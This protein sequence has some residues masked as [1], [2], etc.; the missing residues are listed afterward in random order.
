MKKLKHYIGGKWVYGGMKVKRTSP[1][2]G[3]AAFLVPYAD[4]RTIR[5]AVSVAQQAQKEW[6]T[7]TPANRAQVL[8]KCAEWL[9]EKYGQ[10]GENTA[11]KE[12]IRSSVGKPLAE[13]DIEIIETSDFIRYFCTITAETLGEE[14]LSLDEKLWPTKASVV[15]HA[16]HGV[17]AII[18]PWNYPLEMIAWAAFPAML[19]GNAVLIKPSERSPDIGVIFGEMA[20]ETGIPNGVLNVVLGN[21]ETGRLLTRTDGVDFVSFTGSVAAG[22]EVALESAKRHKGYLL[23]MGGNDPAIVLDDADLE[24]ATNGVLWGK[25]CNAGQV[26]VG[27]KRAYV[28]R[29]VYQEF[30]DKI[31]TKVRALDI[32]RDIG[33]MIDREQVKT[34]DGF[35]RDAKKKGAVVL[36]G[37]HTTNN[38]LTYIPTVLEKVPRA[39]RLYS[40]ECFGPILPLAQFGTDEEAI[41]LA[42]EGNYGLGASIWTRNV[43]RA[44]RIADKLEA[45]MVWINDVNVA[46]PQA[47]WGGWRNSGIGYEL[48]KEA[49]RH[50]TRP[51]HIS[52]EK[53]ADKRRQWWFPY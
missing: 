50:Y 49:I 25:F 38:G 28:A 20:E 41:R 17:V 51:K 45:G 9:V 23:E 40:E 52:Y 5:S 30:R 4:A 36:H 33:P 43:E 27:V 13:A 34:V 11:I 39:A 37:G 3:S 47:P 29:T 42:N 7:R 1:L 8:L 14:H 44:R 32:G 21:G 19:A 10:P 53:S 46:F 26:C 22:R 18:K 12:R 48:S 35:V 6:A 15:V 16:P 31:L 2:T 24:L